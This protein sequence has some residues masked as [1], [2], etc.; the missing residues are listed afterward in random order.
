VP[1]LDEAATIGP[2]LDELRAAGITELIV[3]DGGSCDGTADVARA[4]GAVVVA[5][6]R[7]GYGQACAAGGAATRAQV[8][9]FLDGDGSDDPAF[10]P[11]LVARVRDGHAALALG[12]RTRHEPGAMLAHQMLGNRLVTA[13]LGLVHG[14]VVA[15]IPPMRAIRHDV[16]DALQM[17]EMTYGWPTEMIVKTA[18]AGLPIAQ[19]D[20]RAR[21][22][23]GG[24]S[25]IAGRLAPS[26]MAGVRM[27]GAVLL[28]G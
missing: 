20:V 25:K 19:V 26:L 2:L 4:A 28:P 16:L 3:V 11:S 14:V 12:V 23:A 1:V 21:R 18:R 6:P 5:E 27:L 22:R 13:L 8:L 9:V 17:R 15:D 10:V 7:R 24:E